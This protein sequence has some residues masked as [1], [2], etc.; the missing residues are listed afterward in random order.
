M[1]EQITKLSNNNLLG[2][3]MTAA[4]AAAIEKA[5]VGQPAPDFEMANEEHRE[6]ER[7]RTTLR[8]QG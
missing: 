8:L 1:E 4:T 3:Y 2:G 7:A 6:T 5:Q